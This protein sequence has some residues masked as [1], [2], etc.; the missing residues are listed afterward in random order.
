VNTKDDKFCV[1]EC[2]EP[3]YSKN[4][5]CELCH[6]TCVGCRGPRNTIALDGCISCELGVIH[7]DYTID[8]CLRKNEFCPGE[9]ER[10]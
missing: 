5:T 7:F 1:P 3:K 8:R 2:P 6:E 9:F 4:G 10:L